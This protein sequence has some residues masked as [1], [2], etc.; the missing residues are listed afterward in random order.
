MVNAALPSCMIA[1]AQIPELDTH[2]L[3]DIFDPGP[4]ESFFVKL[5]FMHHTKVE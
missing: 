4:E 3:I 5:G 2:G 1:F